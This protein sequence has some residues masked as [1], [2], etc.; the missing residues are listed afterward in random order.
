MDFMKT[1]PPVSVAPIASRIYRRWKLF[2]LAALVSALA[3]PAAGGARRGIWW[4][5]SPDHPWG[6]GQLMGNPGKEAELLEFLSKWKIDSIYASFSKQAWTKPDLIRAWNERVHAAGKTSHLLL[7]ENTWIAPEHRP[8]LLVT[9]IQRELID[10]NLA[11]GNPKQRFDSL[12][13]DIEPHGLP[14]WKKMTPAARK[15]LLFL[16]R[17]TFRE[18]RVYLDGHGARDIPVF[19]DLPVW[20]DQVAGPVGWG[21]AAER[22][23]WFA[24]LGK[25]LAGISLMAYERDTAKRIEDGVG[26]EIANFEGEVRVG[27]EAVVGPGMTWKSRDELLSMVENEESARPTR[28]VDIHDLVQFHDLMNAR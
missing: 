8:G 13:L 9:H 24:D 7:G 20:F 10:F 23:A 22:D 6:T 17:D 21:S 28:Q 26:W 25:S 5:A 11:A 16:L 3:L 4:W 2:A 1:P 27:L 15:Q 18:V 19:A 12:H 14:G